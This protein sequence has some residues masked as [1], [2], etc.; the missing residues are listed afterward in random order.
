MYMI[1]KIYINIYNNKLII[2]KFLLKTFYKYNTVLKNK[3]I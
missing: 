2:F 3:I 1:N